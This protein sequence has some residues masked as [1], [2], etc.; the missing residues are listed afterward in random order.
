[1]LK[2]IIQGK[3]LKET[4]EAFGKRK[5][6]GNRYSRRRA[7]FFKKLIKRV[8]DKQVEWETEQINKEMKDNYRDA[9][10]EEIKE[11]DMNKESKA[12]H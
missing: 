12:F 8:K 4:K 10:H 9:F 1:M 2:E 11:R 5:K 3:S 6:E 7:N